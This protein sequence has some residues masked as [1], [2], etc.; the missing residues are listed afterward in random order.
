VYTDTHTDTTTDDLI[1]S[2]NVHF[3]L[4]AKIITKNHYL[5]LLG[6]STL[7]VEFAVPV[8]T[9]WTMVNLV[10]GLLPPVTAAVAA[11]NIILFITDFI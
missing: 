10:E 5:L 2:S 3:T 1:I 7:V 11:S 6:G 9:G 4:L 8:T